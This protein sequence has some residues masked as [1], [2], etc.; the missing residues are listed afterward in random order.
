MIG[1]RFPVF[2]RAQLDDYAQNGKTS[3]LIPEGVIINRETAAEMAGES[4]PN[5]RRLVY[6]GAIPVHLI[7]RK[8]AFNSADIPALV[9]KQRDVKPGPKKS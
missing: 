5:F 9:E 6:A 3:I 4:I 7:N 1:E 8:W 2:S